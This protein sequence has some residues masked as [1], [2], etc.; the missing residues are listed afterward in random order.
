MS[1]PRSLLRSNGTKLRL[2]EKQLESDCV[3]RA[4]EHVKRKPSG[5]RK[6]AEE[7]EAIAREVFVDGFEGGRRGADRTIKA[8]TTV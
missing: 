3:G 1:F 5:M 7:S 8:R 2:R 4:L 6:T